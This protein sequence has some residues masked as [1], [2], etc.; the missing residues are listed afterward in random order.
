MHYQNI[1]CHPA[2]SPSVFEPDR[3]PYGRNPKD[4]DA[5]NIGTFAVP[6]STAEDLI[7]RL[8]A[9][10]GFLSDLDL[11]DVEQTIVKSNQEIT[12]L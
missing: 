2:Q 10:Y 3:W 6:T 5:E 9:N 4:M 8:A 12:F 1:F 7:Q 11:D